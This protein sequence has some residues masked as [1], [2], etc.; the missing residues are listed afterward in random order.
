MWLSWQ[1]KALSIF[2]SISWCSTASSWITGKG[3]AKP[4]SACRPHMTASCYSRGIC[5]GNLWF[6]VGLFHEK[7]LSFFFY[8]SPSSG[9]LTTRGLRCT[10]RMTMLQQRGRG[11]MMEEAR[12]TSCRSETS[13]RWRLTNIYL[14]PP[15]LFLK[16][17]FT[18]LYFSFHP[19]VSCQRKND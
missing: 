9:Y 19:L 14:F 3:P 8:F 11:F 2:F 18:G 4:R 13:Q 16:I 7:L 17:V 12:L 10:T 5:S 1:W 6:R 15:S